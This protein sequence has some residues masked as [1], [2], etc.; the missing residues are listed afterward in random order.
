LPPTGDP[1]ESLPYLEIPEEPTLADL[2][3]I[4]MQTPNPMQRAELIQSLAS[5]P[6]QRDVQVL[7]LLRTQASA[8]HPVVR[9]AA[10][11]ALKALFGGKWGQTRAIAPPVQPPRSDDG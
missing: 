4:A 11:E 6:T 8:T 9:N 5:G 1:S 3:R 2:L 10:E 7:R